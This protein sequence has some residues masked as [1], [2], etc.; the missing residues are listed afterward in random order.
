VLTRR[1]ALGACVVGLVIVSPAQGAPA[2]LSPQDVS[3]TPIFDAGDVQVALG[4]DGNA[5]AV[6][7]YSLD[8]LDYRIRAAVRPVGG[9]W[10][11]G[12]DLSALGG[13]D[14]DPQVALDGAGNAFA[15]WR[16]IG[17]NDIVQAAFRPAGGAWQAAVDL[18]AAGQNAQEPQLAVDPAGNA[19][20]VWSRSN[21]TN[22]I[23]QAAYRAAGGTWGQ[24]KDLSPVGGNAQRPEVVLDSAGNAT[25][26]W[27]RHNGMHNQIQAALLPAGSADWLG[28]QTLSVAGQHADDPQVAVDAAG[29]TVVLWKRS[30]GT[31]DVVQAADRLVGESWQGAQ[32]V[33][34][35]GAGRDVQ[36]PQLAVDPAGNAVAVWSRPVG[37]ISTIRGAVR[38]AGGS[39][40][41]EEDLSASGQTAFQPRVVLD[42]RG[43]AVVVWQYFGA[44]A[45]A[46]VR[47]AGGDW[48]APQDL[49]ADGVGTSAPQVAVDAG[50]N[51]LAVWERADVV[52]SAP[53]D[54]TAPLL[55]NVN[56]PVTG[57]ALQTLTFSADP[58][59]A[60]SPLGP[61]V[62]TF[63]D[64]TSA[65]GASVTHTYARGGTYTVAVTQADAAANVATATR[66]LT[67]R[68]AMCFGSAATKIGTEG[69]DVIRGTR[70]ADVIV[71]LAGNDRVRGG[72]GKDKICLGAGNDRGFGGPGNDKLSGGKGRDRLFG[73]G[74][75]D[76]LNGGPG[77]DICR[78]GP[79]RG[80]L[81]AC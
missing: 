4:A 54:A 14:D 38:R 9:P 5:V 35:T 18:S 52:Q 36:T 43:N 73:Q 74:G 57:Y 49:S 78:Q 76:L 31:D 17:T 29:N 67:L 19:L 44:N 40:Q 28:A 80:R 24:P 48:E 27:R 11:P 79:G 47:R 37:S 33:S 20:V 65:S 6:W 68:T 34:V 39:W 58:F 7:W 10:Q 77:R 23:I 30:N 15:V 12:Q 69:N 64:G 62:W 59:D 22:T 25:A 63:G 70:R 41:P 81:I 16:S 61:P 60:W 21:G 53:Y 8:G 45:Q 42:P 3:N 55:R 72:G 75:N 1:L 50:G 32:T 26:V 51:A 56:V 66:S 71:T 46:A 13:E 2:W